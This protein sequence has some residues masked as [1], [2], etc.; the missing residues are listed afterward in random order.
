M[1]VGLV[2]MVGGS[3]TWEQELTLLHVAFIC[4]LQQSCEGFLPEM[5]GL[6]LGWH[7]WSVIKVSHTWTSPVCR[8]SRFC[9]GAELAGQSGQCSGEGAE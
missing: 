5:A 7:S 6:C 1:W 4:S 9:L 8:L 2:L 3:L